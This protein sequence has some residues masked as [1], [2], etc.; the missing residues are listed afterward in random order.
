MGWIKKILLFIFGLIAILAISFFAYKYY[1]SSKANQIKVPENTFA[2]VKINIDD[3]LLEM[4]KNSLSNY[5]DY[6]QSREDTSKIKSPK[7][8]N[9]GLDIPAVLYLFTL[10]DTSYQYYTVLNVNNKSKLESFLTNQLGLSVDSTFQSQSD[11]L[12][13]LHK[14]H[15]TILLG[16]KKMV[17]SLGSKSADNTLMDLLKSDQQNWFL[18]NS[19]G[20]EVKEINDGDLTYVDKNKNWSNLNFKDGMFEFSG[21]FKSDLFRFPSEAL[22]REI[23]ND[24]ILSFQLNTDLSLIFKNRQADLEKLNLPVDSIYQ[25]VGNYVDIALKDKL[26]LERDTIITYD[27]DDNFE[28][29]EKKEVQEIEVPDLSFHIKASP[30][31]LSYLPE[32]IFY[33]FTKTHS[34]GLI[35]LSTNHDLK[36]SEQYNP[37]EY[38]LLFNYVN[39]PL[40]ARYLNW[41]PNYDKINLAE[42][43]GT[44]ISSNELNLFGKFEFNNSRL[45]SFYQLL[46]D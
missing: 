43:K 38:V 15:V 36:Q 39:K 17:L 37:S 29:I 4:F 41:L 11:G 18:A 12:Q 20:E 32:K 28:M 26:V 16:D 2:V 7:I 35:N 5:T 6:Y 10:S 31:L 46:K 13:K 3:L 42:I 34:Q 1:R 33:K 40:S 19:L 44:A 24:N 30:H 25:Y 23:S 22:Q 21:Y 45:H 27:Y 8:W 9:I 14:K